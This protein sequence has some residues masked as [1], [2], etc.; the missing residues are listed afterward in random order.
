MIILAT[1]NFLLAGVK[2]ESMN[3]IANWFSLK[4]YGRLPLKCLPFLNFFHIIWT[5]MKLLND[6]FF[7]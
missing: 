7:G 1:K 2:C 3:Y 6:P 5:S 4:M